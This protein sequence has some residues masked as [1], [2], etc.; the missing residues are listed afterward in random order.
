MP[1]SPSDMIGKVPP[2]ILQSIVHVDVELD[3]LGSM[4][5]VPPCPC[6]VHFG[7]SL[8]KATLTA[9]RKAK[10]E[11]K[12]K[13]AE[14]KKVATAACKAA[15]LTKKKEKQEKCIFI[16]LLRAETAASKVATIRGQLDE[17][18]AA[19]A[20]DKANPQKKIKGSSGTT[21]SISSSNTAPDLSSTRK[22]MS[23]KKRVNVQS[24]CRALFQHITVLSSDEL[25]YM[26]LAS[27]G[28][29]S[30][31]SA[32]VNLDEGSDSPPA[33]AVLRHPSAGR[34]SIAQGGGGRHCSSPGRGHFWA[35]RPRGGLGDDAIM[36]QVRTDM[37]VHTDTQVR[38]Y[39]QGKGDDGALD[40][41]ERDILDG[42]WPGVSDS[43][44]LT[45][46]IA[47]HFAGDVEAYIP[48]SRW[49]DSCTLA[50][51]SVAV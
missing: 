51:P 22:P 34:G 16:A 29:D 38:T 33:A 8:P 15:A 6:P 43:S 28:L 3:L 4:I 11:A 45:C 12:T 7:K 32:S 30:L 2:A 46:F 27:G 40:Q 5:F 48:F 50:D 49:A 17:I 19:T 35:N 20:S 10:K 31:S 13:L 18:E 39:T 26:S 42:I 47:C 1:P 14:E 23:T 37:Q 9:E 21:A 24:P 25:V 41:E 36:G 44:L